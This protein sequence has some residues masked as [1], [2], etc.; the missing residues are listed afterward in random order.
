MQAEDR[1]QQ[2]LQEVQELLERHR[3]FSRPLP[4]GNNL[5][6][7]VSC[8]STSSGGRTSSISSD[9][10]AAGTPPILAS[11]LEALSVDDRRLVWRQLEPEQA[12]RTLVEVGES[13]RESLID[14]L[15]REELAR[16]DSCQL[17]GDDLAYLADSPAG[18]RVVGG[19]ARPR[20]GRP[21]LVPRQPGRG[22]TSPWDG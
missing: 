17:D 8:W 19:F 9:D 2:G 5:M 12:A 14:G 22:L 15:S 1:V 13:V 6:T 20:G 21:P 11:I 7:A 16:G 3:V 4:A 10:S 18:R